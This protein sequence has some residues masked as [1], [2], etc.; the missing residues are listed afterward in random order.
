MC[1]LTNLTVQTDYTPH[2]LIG[3][4]AIGCRAISLNMPDRMSIRENLATTEIII[5]TFYFNQ[6]SERDVCLFI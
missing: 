2:I 3:I 4:S 5:L 1:P 6:R